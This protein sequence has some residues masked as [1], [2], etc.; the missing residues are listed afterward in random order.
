VTSAA[1]GASPASTVIAVI[2]NYCTAKLT[3]DCLRSLEPLVAERSV[4]RVVVADNA[5]PDGSGKAIAEV[6]ESD[7]WGGWAEVMLLDK[8]GGFAFGNNAVIRAYADAPPDYYWLVNSDTIA[9]PNA[10]QH[11]VD[12]AESRPRVG[13][14]GSR[15][16]HLD[17]TQQVSTFRFPTILGEIEANAPVGRLGRRLLAG[18]VIANPPSKTLRQ[19]DWLAGA[20]MLIRR[21]ALDEAGLMDEGYFLYYEETDFCRRCKNHGWECWFVPDSRVVHL[22]GASTGV[23][24]KRPGPPKRRPEYWFA[25]RRR[26]FIKN[27]GR[28]YA[29]ASDIAL[30][31]ATTVNRIA[32]ALRR[33]PT[34]I[35][36]KF[37]FD[38][39]RN[40]ALFNWRERPSAG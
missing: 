13:I 5:S 30:A 39:V 18:S 33:R 14:V 8:N 20:S 38:L 26:Y 15:L 19:C 36:D 28:L 10:L 3:I 17:G 27:H 23:T 34:E 22:I 9:R 25:S 37:V 35:P 40:S 31:T 24:G 32:E 6:I 21:Q 4:T 29:I 7:G 16:E 1:R 2:V 12:F 11:L